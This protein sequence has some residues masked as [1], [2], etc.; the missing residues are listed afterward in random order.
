MPRAPRIGDGIAPIG[1]RPQRATQGL[2]LRDDAALHL[3]GAHD[4]APRD[5]APAGLEL[6]LDQEHHGAAGLHAR[7]DAGA[8]SRSEMNDTSTAARSTGSGTST[9]ESRRAL[10][11]S[12]TITRGSA[13]SLASSWPWPT[14]TA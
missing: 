2:D 7:D 14:S 8:T 6:R 4:A 12:R 1:S 5:L 9:S 3:L 13:R 10:T 11:R